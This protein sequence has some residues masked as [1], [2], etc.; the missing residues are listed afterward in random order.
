MKYI[1]FKLDEFEK[2]IDEIITCVGDGAYYKYK[3]FVKK[4]IDGI[5]AET[6]YLVEQY[7]EEDKQPLLSGQ[8]VEKY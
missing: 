3:Y 8:I 7:D 1:V 4:Y 2:A 5:G 6:L